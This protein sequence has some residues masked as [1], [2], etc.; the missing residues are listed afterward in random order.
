MN[1]LCIAPMLRTPFLALLLLLAPGCQRDELP[2]VTPDTT[3]PL[4]PAGLVVESSHDGFVFLG[5]LKNTEADFLQYIIFRAEEPGGAFVPID[6]TSRSYYVDSRR[7]YD[8]TYYYRVAAADQS[9]NVSSP[10]VVVSAT[11]PNLS[12]PD[13]P[14]EVEVSGHNAEGHRFLRVTWVPVDVHDLRG[15][16]V[17]RSESPN[18]PPDANPALLFTETVFIDDSTVREIG[19]PYYYRI[20]AIDRGDKTSSASDIAFD[21]ITALPELVFPTDQAVIK[22]YPEFRWRGV[23]G[24]VSYRLSIGSSPL[25][26][27]LWSSSVDDNGASEYTL[28]YLGP[29]LYA[30]RGYYW[31]VTTFTRRNGAPN[32]ESPARLF[33]VY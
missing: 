30:A 25:A 8:T 2:P 20:V 17:Y 7:S 27:D 33:Q 15:Y 6:S 11:S 26:G 21:R 23:Q 32:G 12:S 5:W 4:P 10:S 22:G 1:R 18:T 9:A 19:I 24:A 28:P 16:K 14:S 13:T 3:A 29:S 31:R